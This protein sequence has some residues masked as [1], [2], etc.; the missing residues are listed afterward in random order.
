MRPNENSCVFDSSAVLAVLLDEPRSEEVSARI[1]TAAISSVNLAE[2]ATKLADRGLG[3]VAIQASLSG[4][5]LQVMS[6][7]PQLAVQVGLLRTITQAHGLSL[8]DRACLAL[9]QQMKLPVVTADRIWNDLD[10]GVEV[11]LIR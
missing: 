3:A 5:G 4:L 6:F 7:H 1:G 10:V 8:G 9:A 2:V 11:I